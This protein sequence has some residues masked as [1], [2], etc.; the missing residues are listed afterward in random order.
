MFYLFICCDDHG[1]GFY[2]PH[3]NNWSGRLRIGSDITGRIDSIELP[4][5]ATD[6][7]FSIELPEDFSWV[8][9]YDGKQLKHACRVSLYSRTVRLNI[10]VAA[11]DKQE[12]AM[13]K[14]A[15]PR[16]GLT[17]GRDRGNLLCYDEQVVSRTHVQL[18]R[19]PD[20]KCQL[21]M[22]A[23][24]GVFVNGMAVKSN[25]RPLNFGDRILILPALHVIYLGDCVAVSK[26]KTVQP[27]ETLQPYAPRPAG[28]ELPQDVTVVREYHRAP[29]HLQMPQTD[30]I[31]IDP[32][33]ERERH[34]EMPTWLVV[35]PSITMVMPML[36]SSLVSQR[37]IIASMAMIGT[38]A[39]LSIMW[40]SF[41]RKYQKQEYENNEE[42]RKE[43]CRQYY[44]EMEER[45]ASATDR[46]CKRLLHNFPSVMECAKLP[47]S[48]GNRLWERMPTHE[49]FLQLR[50]GLGEKPLPNE[51]SVKPLKIS[52]TDDP[53]RHEPQRLYDQYHIMQDVPVTVD[54]KSSPIIG[55][56]GK[57]TMPWLMQSMVIQA[58][59]NHSYLDVR[60]AI[61]HTEQDADQWR[62]ARWLPHTFATSDRTM[63]MV[64][65]EKNAVRDV[66]AFIDNELTM[67]S[68]LKSRDEEEGT[69]ETVIT[70]T[71]LPWYLLF[72]TDPKILEDSQIVRHL[73]SAGLGFTIILQTPSME[74]LPKECIS[75]IDA[76]EKMG[77][78]Y[79]A[80]GMMTGVRFEAATREMLQRFSSEIAPVRI[81]EV[82]GNAAIPSLV[83]FLETYNVRKVEDLDV[84]YFWNENH[85]YKSVQSILGMKAGGVPFILDIS[86]KNHGPHGLI[87]GTTGAGKSV[88]LQSFILSLSINYSP[89]EIQFILIDYKGGGTSED[90]RDLP[91]AAGVIDS[92]QGERMIFRALASIKG[93]ILRRE[94]I[95]KEVGVNNID[96]YM[97]YYNNDSSEE[98][99]GHLIIIVDE[100]AE[101]KKEQPDFMRE[102]VSAARVGRSLG[103]HLV[104]ATQKP[105]NSVSDEI[106]ANT[107]FRICLRVASR[108]DS[109]EM[110]KRPEAAYL[111]GMGR[112]YVQV[113]NDEL[114]EQVQTSYSGAAYAPDALLPEEEP[115]ILNEAGQPVKLKRKKAAQTDENARAKTE[116]DAVMEKLNLTCEQYHFARARKMWLDELPQLILLN[117]IET[118]KDSVFADGQWQPQPEGELKAYYAMADDIAKQ[119]YFPVAMDF[120]NEKNQIIV[121]L[122][123]TGKTTMLQTI[124]VS[125]AQRYTPAEVN[126]YIFSLTS[127]TLSSLSALPHV[128]EIVYEDEFDEQIRLME[129]INAESERRKKLFAVMSTDNYIQYNRAAREAGGE[130][131]PAIIVMVDRMQQLRDWA[132]NKKE[133]TLNLFY[134]LLRSANSQGI[135]FVLTAFDR[136][137][138]PVKYHPYVHGVALQLTDRAGYS[139]ALAVRIPSDWGG[140]R[141]YVGR[142]MI[143][144][145]NKEE[146]VTYVYEIQSSVYATAESDAKRSEAVRALG[147]QMCEAYKG[148]R[149][150]G[151][152]RIPAEPVL[153]LL[154]RHEDAQEAIRDMDRLPLFYVKN[155]GEVAG[156]NL[157]E[158]FSLLICGSRKSGKSSLLQN[159]AT[160]FLQKGALVYL[161]GNADMVQWG[162]ANGVEAFEH[163]SE[164]WTNALA[165][166]FKTTIG[167]RDKQLVAAKRAGGAEAQLKVLKTFTP[168]VVL[169]D[170]ADEYLAKYKDVSFTRDNLQYFCADNVSKY[171]IYTFVTLSHSAVT[172]TR[173]ERMINAMIGAKRGIMLQGKL[174]ECDPFGASM[175]LPYSM[176]NEA[177]PAGEALYVTDQE[178]TRVVIPKWEEYK[179]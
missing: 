32:P 2:L 9:G 42:H 39:A 47:L 117:S 178:I 46:E 93:E 84:R 133:E 34:K 160:T 98:P 83:T 167:E 27:H 103:M 14:I 59:A 128:G 108:S 74:L 5:G 26:G 136:N 22:R 149:P 51:M 177:Y 99:L 162:Q 145:E 82:V 157:R 105:S 173:S 28:K 123:G 129:M 154:L 137:E 67:H 89:T 45:L 126:I 77:T 176:R 121:G 153:P 81:K 101:L 112:C 62:F 55:I 11:Y 37:S 165:A 69:D 33:I 36:V 172:K 91:H 146:K 71:M 64:V 48:G 13:R 52:L 50:L 85:A 92:L 56:L 4:V 131:V 116:L 20:G 130:V 163:G 16:Q 63:R 21:A 158:S 58:A 79:G 159:I 115:R 138:L 111:K 8:E 122:A 61:L 87:A 102:L 75:V 148:R 88:L 7:V 15:L 1:K 23:N 24:G 114:F 31:E 168:I 90:F 106:E 78:I 49:D 43:V 132:E 54:L 120:T 166:M 171:A 70:P 109:Q 38:S 95:F 119:C 135:Y 113:G 142:G 139:D 150:R 57:K 65:S 80:R 155:T 161:V 100:F 3:T 76:K 60:I 179:E 41:N 72:C 170:D 73:N 86:D 25:A 156:L 18:M 97:K 68:E 169:V 174:G 40:G 10:Y 143:G 110:L 44:A 140:I 118:M 12:T 124:A 147:R 151:I 104:L 35:G 152:A 141:G 164:D 17:I 19:T 96:D 125:L 66:L 94:A 127:R 29:R 6:G 107:R 175:R 53:L 144:E 134:D 30:P